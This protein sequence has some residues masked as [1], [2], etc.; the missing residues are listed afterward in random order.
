[1]SDARSRYGAADV[2][3]VSAFQPEAA[4]SRLR[5]ALATADTLWNPRDPERLTVLDIGCGRGVT[6]ALLAAANP[7]W[8]VIGLDLQPAHIAEAQDLAALAGLANAR[9]IEADLA[10]LDED[11]CARLL[12]E[13]DVVICY[14][15]WTWVPDIVR[16]GIVRLLRSRVRPGGLVLMGYNALPGFSDAVVLQRLIDDIARVM[17]GTPE[18][19]GAAAWDAVAAL[20][21]AGAAYLP[22][23]ATFDRLLTS[24]RRA[25]AYM[26]HEWLTSFW[27]P[28]F[29][30]DLAR[31]LAR[32]RL[33]YG[34]SANPG[35]SLLSLQLTAEQRAALEAAPRGAC[36][37][38]LTDLFLQR[39]FRTDIFVR[40][41]R[42]GGRAILGDI[43]LTLNFAPE[44]IE[45]EVPTRQGGASLPEDQ[46]AV[47]AAAMA[48]GPRRVADLAALPGLPDVGM[49]ELAIMLVEGAAALPLWREV[50]PPGRATEMARRCAA[51]L[52]EVFRA[53]D[54]GG[55]GVL[56]APVPA[57]GSAVVASPSDLAIIVALQAGTPPD[58][59]T[60]A[61]RLLD[62]DAPPEIRAQGQEAI[63][64]VLARRLKAWRVMGLV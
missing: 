58:A 25:P 32:A 46:L 24:V 5:F 52:L 19:R 31:E 55:S 59:A 53:N 50:P 14:G 7:D 23:E 57:L 17:T 56:G 4:P 33:D 49:A 30:A 15:V 62:P 12:P 47:L 54:P 18:E 41:R 43:R 22:D 27:R 39:R 38:T 60:L 45:M 63:G 48:D 37:E 6:A 29:H 9:F 1:M 2:R 26:V 42:G 3:Y 36:R 64:R 13:V 51:A 61:A 40:G 35:R 10:E 20:R 28:V 34:G 44:A 11:A 8:Q 21:Q 16:E